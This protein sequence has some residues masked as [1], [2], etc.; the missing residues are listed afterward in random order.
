[1][2]TKAFPYLKIDLQHDKR[3]LDDNCQKEIK[4]RD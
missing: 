2:S 3:N 1:M 4:L